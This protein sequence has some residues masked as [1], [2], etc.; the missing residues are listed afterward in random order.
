MFGVADAVVALALAVAVSAAVAKLF[1]ARRRAA[2]PGSVP[3]LLALGPIGLAVSGVLGAPAALDLAAPSDTALALVG[4]LGAVLNMVGA[5]CLVAGLILATAPRHV[6]RR[7]VAVQAVVL[8]VLV[9]AMIVARY[10]AVLPDDPRYHT[11]VPASIIV[12]VLIRM[13]YVFAALL[14]FAVMAHGVARSPETDWQVRWGLRVTVAAA[15]AGAAYVLVSLVGMLGARTVLAHQVSAALDAICVI[16]FAAGASLTAWLPS[17]QARWLSLRTWWAHRRLAPLWERLAPHAPNIGLESGGVSTAS[18]EKGIVALLRRV[19]AVHD[20][21]NLLGARA[22]PQAREWVVDRAAQRGLREHRELVELLIEAAEMVTALDAAGSA[23]TPSSS[24]EA[25]S[26]EATPALIAERRRRA[27]RASD[28]PPPPDTAPDVLAAADRL[29]ALYRAMRHSSIV[30]DVRS[31]ARR[32]PAHRPVHAHEHASAQGVADAGSHDGAS[33]LP[34]P[35]TTSTAGG[36][37]Y[38]GTHFPRP[39]EGRQSAAA[40]PVDGQDIV[41]PSA[42]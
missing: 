42:S 6:A 23:S 20:A 19:I 9:A 5:F 21:Q 4:T 41:I 13:G 39:Q 32:A 29:R 7:R 30:A 12:F 1:P 31:A 3:L 26:D 18:Q 10:V 22:H 35:R 36:G 33:P 34:G 37:H 38:P 14:A 2:S 25:A 15:V 11:G 27:R 16:M 24:P 17:L 8:I 40:A 28:Q